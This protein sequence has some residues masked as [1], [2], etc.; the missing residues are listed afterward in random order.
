MQKSS[1]SLNALVIALNCNVDLGTTN[2]LSGLNAK[3]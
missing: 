2:N 1:E 3:A